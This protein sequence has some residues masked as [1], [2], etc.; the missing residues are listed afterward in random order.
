MDSYVS[1]RIASGLLIAPSFSNL[2]TREFS[3]SLAPISQRKDSVSSLSSKSSKEDQNEHERFMKDMN[4][5]S[6]KNKDKVKVNVMNE[7]KKN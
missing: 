1:D 3:C 7:N 2:K 6:L 5:N 4:K